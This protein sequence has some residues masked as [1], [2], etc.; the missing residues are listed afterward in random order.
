MSDRPEMTGPRRAAI[1]LVSIDPDSAARVMTQIGK[2]EQER[3]TLEI[4]KLETEPPTKEERDGVLQEFY[5]IHLAQQYVE[6]GG[7]DYA[8]HRVGIQQDRGN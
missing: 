1:F 3:V 4:A 6:E 8:G 2:D 7:L 5:N